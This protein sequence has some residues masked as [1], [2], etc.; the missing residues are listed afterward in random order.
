M[1]IAI[2]RV[3]HLIHAAACLLPAWFP[4][5]LRMGIKVAALFGVG[6]KNGLGI[7]NREKKS[8]P[9][10]ENPEAISKEIVELLAGETL[11]GVAGKQN[12]NGALWERETIAVIPIKIAI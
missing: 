6:P 8:T 3:D 9:R 11:E 5:G 1:A 10:L 2:G 12:I 4:D 7:W